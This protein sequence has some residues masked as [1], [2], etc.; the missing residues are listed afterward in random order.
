MNDAPNS[1][2]SNWTLPEG[3]V[4]LNH[5]SFGPSPK[6][7]QQART[8]WFEELESQPMQFLVRRT[9][10]ELDTTCE[11]LG[12]FIGCDADDVLLVDN[13]SFA[14]NIAANSV[15]LKAGA[16]VLTTNH[17][18]GSV[19]RLWRKVCKDAGAKL[20]VQRLADPLT[21]PEE[22][23]DRFFEGAT[24]RTRVIVI[25]HVTSPTAAVFPVEEICRR[26]RQQKIM[27]VIDG[28]HA[29][30]M[31]PLN[32][33]RIDC[34]FY[35]ASCHKW[36]SAPFGSGF[37]YVKRR[38]QQTLRPNLI[39]WG[40]S[41]SG[42]ASH[43]KDEFRWIGT[44]DPSAMIAVRDAIRFL[45]DYGIKRFRDETTEL[46]SYVR[47]QVEARTACKVIVPPEWS[48]SMVSFRLPDDGVEAPKHG[49]LD[50]VQ[51]RLQ[52]YQI[53]APVTNWNG[54]RL[55]RVSCYLYNDRADVDHLCDALA[56]I[57]GNG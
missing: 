28:P 52:D 49:Y 41:L 36:L 9:E 12:Q 2:R 38:W 4:Y 10:S 40:G 24:D 18:Y 19:L 20:V 25:S 13:A 54:Q 48:R 15:D 31:L 39:S 17:E 11:E 14:M 47:Q 26:A 37:L 30:A 35:A 23:V 44:R 3:L 21:T 42:R 29:V 50:P 16:E 1:M 55:L 51:G 45:T 33:R 46:A 7:V 53:E 8:R 5:G 43:W 34:D 6:V 22:F 56:E 57:L 27:T 32:M